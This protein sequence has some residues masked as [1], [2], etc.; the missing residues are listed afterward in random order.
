MGHSIPSVTAVSL[1]IFSS[2]V[3][4]P[5]ARAGTK[6]Y[7]NIISYGS[8]VYSVDRSTLTA[9]KRDNLYTLTDAEREALARNYDLLIT[10]H[11]NEKF[12]PDLIKVNP[13]LLIFIYRNI[14]SIDEQSEGEIQTARDN[15]W[16]LLDELGNDVYRLRNPV[17]KLVDIGNPDYR[18]WLADLINNRTENIHVSGVFG[19]TTAVRIAGMSADPINPRTGKVYT[20]QEYSADMLALVKRVREKTGK[21]YIANGNGMLCGSHWAGFYQHRAIAE[22]VVDEVDG[23]L[24]EGFIRFSGDDYW[25]S[26]DDWNKDLEYLDLLNKKGKI[27]LA[28]T[29]TGGN[30]P[31]GATMDQVAMYGFATYLLGKSGDR[32]YFTA[33]GYDD[34][35]LN[36]CKINV[37]I[38]LTNYRT[39]NGGPVHERVFSKSLVMVNPSDNSFTITLEENYLTLDGQTVSE[40]D[41]PAHTGIILLKLG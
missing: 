28:W 11:W 5:F 2:F 27:T 17:M 20:D 25:R 41:L 39:I 33:R 22:P 38:P 36:V 12:L 37:G 1:L 23:V 21:L 34:E 19:D 32:A 16:I 4:P 40:I 13:R 14:G 3:L 18:E 24:L 30:M 35:F 9:T 7:L 6:D 26:V 8:V 15:G 31:P 29:L 10:G